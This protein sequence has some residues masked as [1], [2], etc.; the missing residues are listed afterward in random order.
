MTQRPDDVRPG[1]AR[2][3]PHVERSPVRHIEDTP[4]HTKRIT[5]R[6][7]EA[8]EIRRQLTAPTVPSRAYR[9]R[10]RPRRLRGVAS[11]GAVVFGITMLILSA[12]ALGFVLALVTR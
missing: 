7:V 9:D 4:V 12:A 11:T 2:Y 10:E 8:D 5:E 6:H 3:D 1:Y